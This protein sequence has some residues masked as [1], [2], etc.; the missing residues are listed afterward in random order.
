MLRG[1]NE[2][3]SSSVVCKVKLLCVFRLPTFCPQYIFCLGLAG[4]L[5]KEEKDCFMSTFL[6]KDFVYLTE[7]ES[8]HKQ[9]ERQGREREKQTPH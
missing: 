2:T 5:L 3:I 8:E 4:R 6:N 1:P 9:G 7:R